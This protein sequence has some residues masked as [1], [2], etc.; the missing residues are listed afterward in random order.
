MFKIKH[1]SYAISYDIL[2][3]KPIFEAEKSNFENMLFCT[4]KDRIQELTQIHL[5][6]IMAWVYA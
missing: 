4:F 1:V 5:P 2:E 6:I 3:A